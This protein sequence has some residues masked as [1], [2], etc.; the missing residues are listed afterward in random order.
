MSESKAQRGHISDP[1]LVHLNGCSM[2]WRAKCGLTCER[3]RWWSRCERFIVHCGGGRAVFMWSPQHGELVNYSRIMTVT[4]GQWVPH[5]SKPHWNY[6]NCDKLSDLNPSRLHFLQLEFL[7]QFYSCLLAFL[8]CCFSYLCF[9]KL[10]KQ[11]ALVNRLINI[12]RCS[13]KFFKSRW[14]IKHV[15]R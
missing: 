9:L 15:F 11:H 6:T 13:L 10:L 14:R 12:G 5:H 2:A 4:P 3:L 8:C 1:K 7:C